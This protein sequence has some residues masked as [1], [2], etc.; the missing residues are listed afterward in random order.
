V[1]NFDQQMK[2]AGECIHPHRHAVK[3]I[4]KV[5]SRRSVVL[6]KQVWFQGLAL[7]LSEDV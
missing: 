5:S 2:A 4:C 3:D 7:S 6:S 1:E